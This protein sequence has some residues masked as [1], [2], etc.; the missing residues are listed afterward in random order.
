MYYSQ[1]HVEECKYK[2]KE[3]ALKR[4]ALVQII[5]FL[6]MVMIFIQIEIVILVLKI[7]IWKNIMST[8]NIAELTLLEKRNDE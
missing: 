3:E 4:S 8:I 5:L 7:S 1:I 6:I 2:V